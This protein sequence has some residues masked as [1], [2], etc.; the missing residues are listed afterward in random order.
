[1]TILSVFFA[2][3]SPK[4]TR[5]CSSLKRWPRSLQT[6]WHA[7]CRLHGHRA[8]CRLHSA[9]C[10]LREVSRLHGTYI[11]VCKL[12]REFYCEYH[13]TIHY[14]LPAL[15]HNYLQTSQEIVHIKSKS[16]I[17]Y[18]WAQK[19]VRAQYHAVYFPTQ[20]R[21][22]SAILGNKTKLPPSYECNTGKSCT[23]SA[24][25]RTW[26]RPAWHKSKG[27]EL[28]HCMQQGCSTT[29]TP[30]PGGDLPTSVA[31]QACSR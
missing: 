5:A 19:R 15:H 23:R 16:F 29:L 10:R 25:A 27:L 22:V 31:F 6:A 14:A 21:R 8:V 17:I 26:Y 3:I 12:H 18:L 9:V 4:H 2:V 30:H 28:F 13:H 1:M 7:V 20:S 24:A 11:P